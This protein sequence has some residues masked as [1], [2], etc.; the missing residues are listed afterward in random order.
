MWLKDPREN[1]LPGSTRRQAGPDVSVR[2]L[3]KTVIAVESRDR[4]W[5]W[6]GIG[7]LVLT[8]VRLLSWS[9]L[10]SLVLGHQSCVPCVL[11]GPSQRF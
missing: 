3:E 6:V 10:L 7:G 1:Q 2:L 8:S 4:V 11:G 5:G 9:Y